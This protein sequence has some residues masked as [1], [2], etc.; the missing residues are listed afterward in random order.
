LPENAQLTIEGQPVN[1]TSAERTLVSPPLERGKTYTYSLKA[2]M[3]RPGGPV[4]AT[5]DVD[6]RAGETARVNLTFPSTAPKETTNEPIPKPAP[7]TNQPIPS[8]HLT[9]STNE[10]IPSN[11]SAPN[12]STPPK[13]IP[14]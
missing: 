9:P 10:S 5:K 11:K 2:K 3:D 14:E 1:S 7:S 8:D 6:V 12:Q 13:R 4:T